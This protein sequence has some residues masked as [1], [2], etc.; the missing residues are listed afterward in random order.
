[1]RHLKSLQLVAL[2]VAAL[3]VSACTPLSRTGEQPLSPEELR[4]RAVESKLGEVNRRINAVE[5]KE[6]TKTQDELRNLRG[7]IERLRFDLD[8][9]TRR[10]KDVGGDIERRLQK[11]ESQPVAAPAVDATLT[12]PAVPP[13]IYA[14]QA[15]TT[16]GGSTAAEEQAAYLKAFDSLKAGKYDAAITG[17]KGMIDK[18]PQGNFADNAW[19]WLGESQY[20]KRQYKPAL[21]SYT[22]LIER[23]PASPKVPDAL[24]K[25]GLS[26]LEL[27]QPDQAKAIW[28]R[29]I[30]DYPNANAAG[31]ARQR[32]AQTP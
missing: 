16:D 10:S 14:P 29:V 12:T 27:K 7:E 5:G 6:D 15:A 25:S 32:L 20:V 4:M 9:Q 31:L 26:Q 24:F 28:R 30:K 23:F 3:A 1:M 17:F 8:T 22:A 11:L 19:Y 18:W 13:V 21:D 2:L